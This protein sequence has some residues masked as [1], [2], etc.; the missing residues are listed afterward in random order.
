MLSWSYSDNESNP[1][2]KFVIQKL[3]LESANPSW[4]DLANV[5]PDLTVFS[6]GK[7]PYAYFYFRVAAENADGER[8]EYSNAYLVNV[9]QTSVSLPVISEASVSTDSTS[10]LLLWNFSGSSVFT[11]GNF[12]IE[13]LD[14]ETN[15]WVRQG[16][17]DASTS[18]F[19]IGLSNEDRHFRVLAANETDTLASET[20]TVPAEVLSVPTDISAKRIAPSVW[21]L[22]WDY[23]KN[24]LRKEAG[25][26]VQ[27]S[28]DGSASW[29]EVSTVSP[30][31][32]YYHVSGSGN[33]E[34]FFRVAAF[35]DEDTT[36]FTAAL[37]IVANTDDIPYRDDLKL[38]TPSVTV[39]T[40]TLMNG[41]DTENVDY[42]LS[43]ESDFMNKNILNSEY[44]DEVSY[45]AAGIRKI[46]ARPFRKSSKTR[47]SRRSTRIF[48]GTCRWTRRAT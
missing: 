9:S 43:I 4:S 48:P 41:E 46:K 20:Y 27:S 42:V 15:E 12:L 40:I 10:R 34:K 25:F 31:I 18:R 19:R 22:T 44:T 45:E 35:D 17:V 16:I 32:L 38:T 14:L 11:A 1:A 2:S 26:L 7:L 30:G 21:E 33:L 8:S 5:S 3:N 37:Q 24:A 47:G 23:S 6:L 28:A 39:S 36:A 29:S 13:K